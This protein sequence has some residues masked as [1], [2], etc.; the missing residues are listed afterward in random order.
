MTSTSAYQATAQQAAEA[1]VRQSDGTLR[2]RVVSNSM[3]PWLRADDQVQVTACK[4]EDVIPGDLLVV[5]GED[6]T[7]QTHRFVRLTPQG[8]VLKGDANPWCDSPV[9][10]THL[11][12]RVSGV[13]RGAAFYPWRTLCDTRTTKWALLHARLT[14]GRRH[15]LALRG[16]ARFFRLGHRILYR[17]KCEV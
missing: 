15:S 4:P 14:L 12:G 10:P 2:V 17:L 13:W 1:Y 6:N 9:P 8:L 5:V 16:L 3:S 7:W 11:I